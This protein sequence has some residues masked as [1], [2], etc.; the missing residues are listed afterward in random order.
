[1]LF[2]FNSHCIAV[3]RVGFQVTTAEATSSLF[4]LVGPT[5]PEVFV[6]ITLARSPSVGPPQAPLLCARDSCRLFRW[7]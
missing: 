1:M 7:R 2:F 6:G 3:P 5:N 4:V